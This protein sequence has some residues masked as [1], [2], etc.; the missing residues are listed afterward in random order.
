[1]DLARRGGVGIRVIVQRPVRVLRV[2]RRRGERSLRGNRLAAQQV[3]DRH[4]VEPQPGS[5]GHRVLQQAGEVAQRQGDVVAGGL[6]RGEE[7]QR[8]LQPLGQ[9]DQAVQTLLHGRALRVGGQ[10]GGQRYQL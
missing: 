5:G 9:Q 2:A 8:R 1:M 4:H 3:V 10:G 7:G 6:G